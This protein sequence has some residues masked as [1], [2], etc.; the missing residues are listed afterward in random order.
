LYIVIINIMSN[1]TT[2]TQPRRDVDLAN[3]PPIPAHITQVLDKIFDDFDRTLEWLERYEGAITDG[4]AQSPD[5]DPNVL[6]ADMGITDVTT[7]TPLSYEDIA[8]LL[9]DE[10]F[11]DFDKKIEWLAE[12]GL[13]FAEPDMAINGQ[14]ADGE[15][16]Q[17]T[18]TPATMAEGLPGSAA[19]SA[20]NLSAAPGTRHQT[21]RSRQCV[22]AR[23]LSNICRHVHP[24]AL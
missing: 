7:A 2:Q 10:L 21:P 17:S 13:H 15:S 3:L 9:P 16:T 6:M 8:A 23:E 24:R 1:Q 18:E 19:S 22:E 12:G 20:C 14:V 4:T 5:H 11:G